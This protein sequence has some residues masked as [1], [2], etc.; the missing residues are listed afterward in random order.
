MKYSLGKIEAVSEPKY[1]LQACSYQNYGDIELL[2]IPQHFRNN[3]SKDWLT[4]E[5]KEKHLVPREINV[6]ENLSNPK[7][8]NIDRIDSSTLR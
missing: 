5:K 6:V 4:I 1:H 2:E 7:K 3:Y 8:I